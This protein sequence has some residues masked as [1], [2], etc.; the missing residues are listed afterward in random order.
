MTFAAL[1]FR[2]G[3]FAALALLVRYAIRT[4]GSRAGTILVAYLALMGA[5]H[6]WLVPTAAQAIGQPRPYSP[7]PSVGILPVNL[8]IAAGWIFAVLVSLALARLIQRRHFP[9]TNVFL[10]M[11][12]TALITTAISYPVEVMGTRVGFWTWHSTYTVPWLPFDWPFDAFEGWPTTS[13]MIVLVYCTIRYRLFSARPWLRAGVLV[14]ALAAYGLSVTQP[15]RITA[16]YLVVATVLGFVA[17][18]RWLG[19]SA[20]LT[21]PMPLG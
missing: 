10:T 17:P 5:C 11:A 4:E 7:G 3:A 8:V 2:G 15:W 14:L 20:S 19:T 13:L 12:L 1:L 6:E 21:N 18:S 9:S 16:P